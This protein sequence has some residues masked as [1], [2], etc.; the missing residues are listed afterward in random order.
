MEF[1]PTQLIYTWAT[2]LSHPKVKFPSE[3]DTTH[4]HNHWSNEELV[5]SLLKKFLITFIQT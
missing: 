5:I 2:D 3:F 1:L 4:S